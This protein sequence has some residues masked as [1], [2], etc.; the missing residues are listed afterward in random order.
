MLSVIDLQVSVRG[1]RILHDVNL[2]IPRGE[3]HAL[4]GPNGSGKSVM[5]MT[6]MGYP[7]YEIRKGRIVF[8]GR[9][10]TRM[11]LDERSRLGIGISEQRPPTI[12]GVKLSNMVKLIASVKQLS[13]AHTSSIASAVDINRFLNRDIND[14]LSGGESKQTE[15]F[16][17][18]LANPQLLI[19]DEPDSGVDP[20]QLLKIGRLIHTSLRNNPPGGDKRGGYPDARIKAGLI[21]THSAEILEYVQTDKAHLMMDGKIKCSGSPNLM[22]DHIRKQGYAYCVSCLEQEQCRD[23]NNWITEN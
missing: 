20:E 1:K 10:V 16:L 12:K 6:I 8:D 2:H 3:V 14:G 19:L 9:D 17:L 13:D 4:F 21:S 22:M 5:M 15:L 23:K 7:E 18:L 11:S